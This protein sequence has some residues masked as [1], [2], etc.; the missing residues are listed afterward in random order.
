MKA[1][2][3]VACG[4]AGVRPRPPGAGHHVF[5]HSV[6]SG[7]CRRHATRG[8]PRRRFTPGFR[9]DGDG[10]IPSS[11]HPRTLS[12][13]IALKQPGRLP[14]GSTV[15]ATTRIGEATLTKAL[16][17]GDPDVT[18]S[19][20]QPAGESAKVELKAEGTGPSRSTTPSGSRR[21]PSR[22]TA[23]RSRPSRTTRPRPPI[24]S[25]SGRPSTASPT[26][27]PTGRSASS[28]PRPRARPARTGS[29]SSSPRTRPSSPSS[30]SISSTATCPPTSG[31]TSSRTA[32]PSNTR[33][34]ST[35][36]ASSASGLPARGRTSSP[37]A[38]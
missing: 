29:G 21:S 4:A 10:D 13:A 22:T 17:L 19:I 8:G 18:W 5:R 24:R 1:R 2:A 35:R 11:T 28:R 38:S 20:A 37:P 26:T 34:A 23:S 32:S 3:P 15:Q 12:V 33:G 16:H 31:S 7:R 25:R 6:R 9:R 36:R 14:A 30:P 27:G